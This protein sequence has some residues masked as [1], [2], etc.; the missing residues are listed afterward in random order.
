VSEKAERGGSGPESNRA[1]NDPA[2]AALALARAS[3]ERADSFL[4]KQEALI[5]AQLHHLHE[6]IKH[7][8]LDM[9]EKRLGV[10]LRVA[11]RCVGVAF[12]GAAGLIVWDAA[13]NEILLIEHF[14]EPTELA[15]R[16]PSG[17]VVAAKLLDDL[18]AVHFM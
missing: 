3:R 13:H 11:T 18:L 4:T 12:A 17:E 2:V 10:W 6:Q 5:S 1:G 16:G 7:L 15:V 8:H 14:S 9:W